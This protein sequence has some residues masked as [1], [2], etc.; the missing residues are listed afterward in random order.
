MRDKLM[1]RSRAGVWFATALVI[2]SGVTGCGKKTLPVPPHAEPVPAV[3]DLSHEI[4]GA[5]VTLTWTVPGKVQQG[6][7]GEGEMILS[8]ARTKLAD[9]PCTGC[10]LVFQRIAVL[11]FPW[12]GA[13]TRPSYSEGLEHGFRYT[14]RVVL[15]MDGGRSSGSSNLAAFDY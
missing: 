14:Y 11:P 10:P 2:A 7:F 8:R 4:D 13:G 1:I 6:S 15:H 3:S 12:A 9:G 5:Q